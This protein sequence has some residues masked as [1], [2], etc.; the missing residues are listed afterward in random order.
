MTRK[1]PP[2]PVATPTTLAAAHELMRR[3]MPAENAPVRE[4]LA[5]RRQSSAVYVRVADIDRGHHHEA[6]Y[7]A[8]RE[9]EE[10]DTLQARL[11]QSPRSEETDPIASADEP[12]GSQCRQMS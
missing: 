5:F 12:K 1:K 7:W 2:D 4:W 10:A 9:R 6:L 8:Q 3:L 11:A